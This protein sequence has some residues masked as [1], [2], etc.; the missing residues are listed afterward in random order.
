MQGAASDWI[1][2]VSTD[3]FW[4][5]PPLFLASAE[6]VDWIHNHTP[7][8]FSKISNLGAISRAYFLNSEFPNL[9]DLEKPRPSQIVT[10]WLVC[11]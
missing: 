2:Q 6:V 9:G 4:V 5:T 1:G 11:V 8:L 7:D 3:T 10:C